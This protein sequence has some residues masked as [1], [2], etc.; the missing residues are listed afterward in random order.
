MLSYSYRTYEYD[1]DAVSGW[2]IDDKYDILYGALPKFGQ[3]YFEIKYYS[4]IWK[5]I[6]YSYVNFL[7]LDKLISDKR[8]EII[9]ELVLGL[10]RGFLLKAAEREFY[11]NTTINARKFSAVLSKRLYSKFELSLRYLQKYS[12][13]IDDIDWYWPDFITPVSTDEI[14]DYPEITFT[15]KALL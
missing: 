13:I 1:K 11:V 4:P 12:N 2:Y 14:L 10:G 9:A 7:S 3:L 5:N 6:S 15:F 8:N